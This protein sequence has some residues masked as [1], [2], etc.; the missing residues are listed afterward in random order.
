MNKKE[1]IDI[2]ALKYE[3]YKVVRTFETPR[4]QYYTLLRLIKEN[5]HLAKLILTRVQQN[6]PI[7][8]PFP[9]EC[10]K[11]PCP[12][13]HCEFDTLENGVPRRMT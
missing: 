6:K 9:T 4:D 11:F 5:E 1:K 13:L 8:C 10:N 2:Q 7:Y 12:T 3:C